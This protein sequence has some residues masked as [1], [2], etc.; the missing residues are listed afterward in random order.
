MAINTADPIHA[1]N[2]HYA[3]LRVDKPGARLVNTGYDGIAVRKG[4]KYD[5]SLFARLAGDGGAKAVRIKASLRGKD[6][7]EIAA[8]TLTVKRGGW[9]QLAATLTAARRPTAPCWH[10][11]RWQPEAST[12]TW[13]R[14]SPG[15]R[16]RG[17]RTA[18]GPTLHR[19]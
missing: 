6:G 1:N 17:A 13:C 4:G 15:I 9:K 19:P 18:C 8:A 2:P 3:T 16:S 7:R 11:N 10:W 14:Y 12:S 5:L